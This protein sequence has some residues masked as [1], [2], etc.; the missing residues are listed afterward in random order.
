[1]IRKDYIMRMIEEMVNA[2]HYALNLTD[3]QNFSQAHEAIGEALDDLINLDVD[4]VLD[5]DSDELITILQLHHNNDWRERTVALS[6]LLKAEGDVAD[7]AGHETRQ[8]RAYLKSLQ[9]Y[10]LAEDASL[11]FPD[12]AP[13]LAGLM[14]VLNEYVLPSD[15]YMALLIHYERTNQLAK[16]ED[17]LFTWVEEIGGETAVSSGIL[18]LQTLLKKPDIQLERGGLTRAEIEESLHELQEME[19]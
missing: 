19:L 17:V 4:A 18:Y 7:A 9:L 11:Q 1:M 14:V 5:L 13:S 8:F 6:A 16:G 2:I 12:L 3:K 10:L 15:T